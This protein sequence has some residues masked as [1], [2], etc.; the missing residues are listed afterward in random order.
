MWNS[1]ASQSSRYA[2]L[3]HLLENKPL[4]ILDVGCGTGDLYHYIK[5]EQLPF[6]YMGIDLSAKMIVA[7]QK[8]YP[9]GNFR[10]LAINDI[11]TNYSFDCV[12]ASGIF[13]LSMKNHEDQMLETILS[14]LDCSTNLVRFNLLT[15]TFN[16]KSK[17]SRFVYA[18]TKAL[19]K[20]LS[21]YVS[22]CEIIQGYLP[23]DA[24]FFLKK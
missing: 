18:N 15:N 5:K 8:A 23:N 11:K 14:M 24:T 3:C 19:Q 20:R 16:F 6:E 12:M 2:I 17:D 1:L 4:S 9:A 22:H 13:N 7:A 21:A 10:C